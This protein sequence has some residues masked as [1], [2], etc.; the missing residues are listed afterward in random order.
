MHPLSSS[1]F[2]MYSRRH[3]A[4]NG[5]GTRGDY[6]KIAG[7]SVFGRLRAWWSKDAVAR[8]EEE[9]RMTAIERDRAEE[10][11]ESRKDDL[12]TEELYP[13]DGADF[14]RDSEPPRP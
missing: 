3:G 14:E 13:H 9:T 6:E 2:T 10:S 8:A 5:F 4:H 11:I 12:R 7:M 1:A